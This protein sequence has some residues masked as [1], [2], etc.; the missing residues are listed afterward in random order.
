MSIAAVAARPSRGRSGALAVVAWIVWAA[1]CAVFV[2]VIVRTLM[3]DLAPV[4]PIAVVRSMSASGRTDDAV[5]ELRKIL[6]RS[7]HDGQARMELARIL[8][9]RKEYAECARE[10]GAVPIWWP[11]KSEAAFLEGQTYKLLNRMREA[12]AAWLVCNRYDPFHPT[13]PKFESAANMELL[14]LYAYE[15]RWDDA[16]RVIWNAYDHADPIDHPA[17]LVMRIRTEMERITPE[18][19]AAKL[20]VWVDAD[21]ADWEARLALARVEQTLGRPDEADR[22]I[23]RCLEERPNDPRAHRVKLAILY[24]RGD[25][26]AITAALEKLPPGSDDDPEI[27]KFRALASEKR[28]D[29]S[30]AVNSYLQA[31]RIRP[32]D[33]ELHYKLSVAEERV[34]NRDRAADHRRRNQELR[35]ARAEL[36]DAY[37]R[38]LDADKG[39]AGAPD[40]AV[41]IRRLADICDRL[42]W[43]RVAEGWRRLAQAA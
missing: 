25:L 30:S 15:E 43:D 10:L 11:T 33:A 32:N 27:W 40:R 2:A 39:R 29:W 42:G 13:P 9:S 14:E 8:G 12:E 41:A 28:G 19:A 31:L 21:P 24:A 38:Y 4:A 5:G 16:H 20:R 17:I 18:S 26:E 34:G 22:L 35:K 23:G 36:T 1:V 3:L 7:P 6:R 37:E